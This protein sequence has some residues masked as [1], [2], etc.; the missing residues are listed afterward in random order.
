[1]E[2][3][4]RIGHKNWSTARKNLARDTAPA[5]GVLQNFITSSRLIAASAVLAFFGGAGLL[6][7]AVERIG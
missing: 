5:V 3:T 6:I 2:F 4:Q 1:M 7:G